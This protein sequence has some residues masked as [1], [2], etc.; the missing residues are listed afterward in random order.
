MIIISIT[1]FLYTKVS[2]NVTE[3]VKIDWLR[4]KKGR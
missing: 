1:D 4:T 3:G 2:G